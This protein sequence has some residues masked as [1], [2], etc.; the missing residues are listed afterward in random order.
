M[1]SQRPRKNWKKH[2][3]VL[4]EDVPET[5]EPEQGEPKDI[6]DPLDIPIPVR[7]IPRVT[8]DMRSVMAVMEVAGDSPIEIA[9][10]FGLN[11]RTV[12]KALSSVSDAEKKAI[13]KYY[14]IALGSQH[15]RLAIKAINAA[16]A[17][18]FNE[19]DDKGRYQTTLV[20]LLTAAGI[21]TDHVH[22]ATEASGM[23]DR[24]GA[25]TGNPIADFVLNAERATKAIASL[26]AGSKLKLHQ[27]V[28]LESG[29]SDD[30]SDS[31]EA[32]WS[33]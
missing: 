29:D 11:P 25:G 14:S 22:K 9:D 33:S 2:P 6:R 24:A 28:E 5:E 31:V 16:M 30:S 19:K 18:D 8:D 1:A 7:Q 3:K 20:Q 10:L 13:G 21:S 26:P 12:R 32:T 4:Y 17:R 23:T 15:Y 27:S